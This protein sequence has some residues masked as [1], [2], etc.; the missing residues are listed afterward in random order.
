MQTEYQSY[1]KNTCRF[2]DLLYFANGC[3]TKYRLEFDKSKLSQRVLNVKKWQSC[4]LECDP[5]MLQYDSYYSKMH[6]MILWDSKNWSFAVLQEKKRK[7]HFQNSM[8]STVR[9]DE[10]KAFSSINRAAQNRYG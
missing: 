3:E 10:S 1:I 7:S 4:T 5:V 9:W 2:L 8:R 6:N